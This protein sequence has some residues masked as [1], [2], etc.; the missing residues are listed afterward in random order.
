MF[1]K[2]K[3]INF[4]YLTIFVL[5]VFSGILISLYNFSVLFILLSVLFISIS[6]KYFN[7]VLFLLILYIPFQVAL[8][9]S[10]GIDLASGRVL[11]LYLFAVWVIKSLAEKKF[12]IR[13]S[14]QTLLILLFLFIAVFSMLQAWDMERA[15]R[16]ILVFLS[17]FPLYFIIT[18]LPIF[19]L[20]KVGTRQCLVSTIAKGRGM[21]KNNY[22]Y[23]ILN[24]LITSGFVLSL[25]GI[26]QFV[27]QFLIGIDPIMDFWSK[28]VSPI[29]Y[30]NTFGAE[31]IA[32]P[33]WLVNISG[34]T[35]LRAFSLFPDPHM[36]SFYLGLLIPVI[37]AIV[38]V[39][40]NDKCTFL[41]GKL[42]YLIL[43][44]M[45]LAEALTFSR[46]GY[47]G[48]IAGIGVTII[49]LW[50]YINFNKKII[51]GLATG[52]SILFI[53]FS[54]QSIVN[55]FLS[56]FNFNEGSNTERIKNWSQGY[57]MFAD[58]FLTGVGI[59]NYS[60]YL[61]PTAGY[62][63]PI[64]AHNLYLDIGAEM[65]IFAL[66]VWLILIGITIW[67]LFKTGKRTEDIFIRALSFGLIGSL[68]W[69][70]AH[71]F[72]DTAIYSPTILTIFVVII[73][74]SMMVINN[75]SDRTNI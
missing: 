60:I 53:I 22:I 25:I 45:L 16:K 64:Y 15:F 54:N 43:F 38:L 8:N 10:A 7:Q 40:R 46:G 6:F 17:I 5:A 4:E 31:V 51:L 27:L 52:I 28:F 68:I 29:F 47:I 34:A 3:K 67:Q 2:L 39:N 44:I 30:G 62:R 33:S 57:E 75:N 65:G 71:S 13:F 58:N 50:K 23:K 12:A 66:L 59:G 69:F 55:R 74:L 49:L 56:S 19:S 11:I 41:N 73:S 48:L 63:T 36:F 18:S 70:S 37:L 61:Y 21:V 1:L 32:N 24:A 9:I 26:I 20:N 72:F 14:L 42:L 35:V